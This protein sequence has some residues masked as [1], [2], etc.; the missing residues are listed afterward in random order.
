MTREEL[1]EA[2][3]MVHEALLAKNNKVAIAQL[4]HALDN[5]IDI[6]LE[7]YPPESDG[8]SVGGSGVTMMM[9]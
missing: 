1:F 9:K 7:I 8:V 2:R 3:L 4:R 6:L 5:I